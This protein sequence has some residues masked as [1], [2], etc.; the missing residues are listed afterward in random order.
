LR[1]RT[2]R[3]RKSNKESRTLRRGRTSLAP[4][5]AFSLQALRAEQPVIGFRRSAVFAN[6]AREKL[7]AGPREFAC[8]RAGLADE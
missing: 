5:A 1:E 4:R 2:R 6:G 3:F 7:S 8:R